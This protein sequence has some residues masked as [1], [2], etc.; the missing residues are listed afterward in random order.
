MTKQND[1][2]VCVGR[3][4][5]GLASIYCIDVV[6]GAML[7]P[8]K[9]KQCITAYMN[10]NMKIGRYR[11]GCICWWSLENPGAHRA[12]NLRAY[13]WTFLLII[14]I[15]VLTSV[16]LCYSYV[17]TL[18]ASLIHYFLSLLWGLKVTYNSRRLGLHQ[19]IWLDI[20]VAGV[21]PVAKSSTVMTL[22]VAYFAS[23]RTIVNHLCVFHVPNTNGNT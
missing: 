1:A 2:S 18:E 16:L 9:Y 12:G 4:C 17:L 3:Y 19:K 22:A 7:F 15:T 23:V 8:T 13:D 20:I 10:N 5:G 14:A 21:S 11:H 6:V